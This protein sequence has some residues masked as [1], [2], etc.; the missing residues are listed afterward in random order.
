MTTRMMKS[1]ALA[2]ML[3]L[4][5]LATFGA[6]VY[7]NTSSPTGEYYSP[8]NASL[9][10]QFGD[11]VTLA[12]TER[13]ITDFSF[14]M[15]LNAPSVGSQAVTVRF[16]EGSAGSN[17]PGSLL[18]T[19]DPLPLTTGFQTYAINGLS[20][21]L[22]TSSLVWAVQFTGL[23]AGDD[24]G[25]LVY[26]PPAIGSSLN[27]FWEQASSGAWSL[28][29]LTGG[30]TPANFAARIAAVPEPASLALGGLGV[31]ALVGMRRLK[32]KH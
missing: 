4:A 5:P 7:D 26:N 27:D 3:S 18:Y 23:G 29:Q 16:Y 13:T 21:A 11:Q 15:Y 31:L 19:S 28:L 8:T 1:V 2:A 14:E 12:G 25:L 30:T 32:K 22:P 20:V 17:P 6:V 9:V 24:A 10:T